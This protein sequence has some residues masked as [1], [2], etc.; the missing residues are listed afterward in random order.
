M[1]S[2]DLSLH[3]AEGQWYQ[4]LIKY[5]DRVLTVL[6]RSKSELPALDLLEVAAPQVVEHH[7]FE[8]HGGKPNLYS[9][10]RISDL[11]LLRS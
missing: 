6:R 4:R 2:F 1:G 3:I 7:R 10:V 5:A 11:C 9:Y 8:P